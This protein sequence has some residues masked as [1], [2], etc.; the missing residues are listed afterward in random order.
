M[1]QVAFNLKYGTTLRNY[2]RIANATEEKNIDK[3]KTKD[4]GFVSVEE[5]T[6]ATPEAS[7]KTVVRTGMRNGV[8][9]VQYSDGSIEN[10]E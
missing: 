8:K 2:E 9:I 5:I 7:Q 3:T 10:A 4:D 6:K 1:G